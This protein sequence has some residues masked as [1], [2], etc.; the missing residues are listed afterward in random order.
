MLID[1][2][3]IAQKIIIPAIYVTGVKIYNYLILIVVL[4]QLMIIHI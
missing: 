1:V 3:Y 2:K 4:M